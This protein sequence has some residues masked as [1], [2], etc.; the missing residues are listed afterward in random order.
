MHR[1]VLDLFVQGRVGL[2]HQT[3][4]HELLVGIHLAVV[5][6]HVEVGLDV[7]AAGVVPVDARDFDDA[8]AGEAMRAAFAHGG[9]VAAADARVADARAFDLDAWLDHVAHRPDPHG[10]AGPR[11]LELGAGDP[12]I[13]PHRGQH[14]V[15]IHRE[16]TGVVPRRPAEDDVTHRE[17]AHLKTHAPLLS[18]V[19][20]ARHGF[21]GACR[22]CGGLGAMSWPPCF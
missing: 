6:R 2:D 8:H 22:T 17:G 7:I 11:D 14:G 21:A 4:V 5:A 18:R 13:L 16:P 12:R 1:V 10:L 3:E 19:V 20:E 9:D 15:A